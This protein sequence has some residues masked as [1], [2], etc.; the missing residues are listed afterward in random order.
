MKGRAIG[1]TGADA[2]GGT[3][4]INAIG[5]TGIDAIG[6]TGIEAI[7][8]TGRMKGRAIGGTGADAIGGT[9]RINA[10]GGTGIDAI[11]GTGRDQLLAMGPIQVLS[12]EQRLISVHGRKLQLPATAA[13]AELLAS[14]V[15]GAQI[16]VALVGTLSKAARMKNTQMHRLV[17]PYVSGVTEVVHTDVVRSMDPATARA[18]VGSIPVDLNALSSTAA[19]RLTVG[20]TVTVRGTMPQVGQPI[21]ASVVIEHG[22]D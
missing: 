19:I 20:S 8:G 11:G 6:G 4:R 9:G 18:T 7:G 5:G 12:I 22:H 16:Q 14:A 13:S 17:A 3:G 2:I 10:I 1:G 15:S 21:N